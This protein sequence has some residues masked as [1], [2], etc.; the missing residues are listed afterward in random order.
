MWVGLA[1]NDAFHIGWDE[2]WAVSKTWITVIAA[3]LFRSL[4]GSII[5]EKDCTRAVLICKAFSSRLILQSSVAKI[6]DCNPLVKISSFR[7][8]CASGWFYAT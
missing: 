8:C 2:H 5:P 7:H 3:S 4:Q 1:E 6:D